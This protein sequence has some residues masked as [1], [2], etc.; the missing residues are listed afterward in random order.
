MQN[1]VDEGDLLMTKSKSLKYRFGSKWPNHGIPKSLKQPKRTNDNYIRRKTK[2]N[3]QHKPNKPQRS[4]NNQNN[5]PV[6]YTQKSSPKEPVEVRGHVPLKL[7][8]V[9]KSA[10]NIS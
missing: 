4:D 5:R 6:G 7:A 3:G 2:I 1:C 8:Y 9:D 10:W